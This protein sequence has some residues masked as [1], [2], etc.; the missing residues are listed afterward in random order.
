M[1][2][3]QKFPYIYLK[4]KTQQFPILYIL[5]LL[6]LAKHMWSGN[7]WKCRRCYFLKT[8]YQSRMLDKYSLRDKKGDL[9]VGIKAYMHISSYL[10]QC[11]STY[12]H[13]QRVTL[14]SILIKK[15][16]KKRWGCPKRSPMLHSYLLQSLRN[17]QNPNRIVFKF[18]S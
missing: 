7:E 13:L 6:L 18:L 12:L 16:K 1:N 11:L 15:Q 8:I 14:K 2:Y 10:C 3:S 17:S 9:Y 4:K 5:L